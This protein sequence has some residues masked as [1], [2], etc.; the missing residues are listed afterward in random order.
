MWQARNGSGA[1]SRKFSKE[2][3][4]FSS[5]SSTFIWM[6]AKEFQN[7]VK[8]YLKCPFLKISTPLAFTVM[9]EWTQFLLL[10]KWT[11]VFEV[12]F[13]FRVVCLCAFIVKSCL[14]SYLS[15]LEMCYFPW[16]KLRQMLS[17]LPSLESL[18]YFILPVDEKCLVASQ[19][20]WLV[21]PRH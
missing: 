4:S 16:N 5:F 2:L 10:S 8:C 3:V 1:V 9:S 14:H 7:L 11:T 21:E 18:R 13:G 15:I 17:A 19:P 20:G 6:L 12:L